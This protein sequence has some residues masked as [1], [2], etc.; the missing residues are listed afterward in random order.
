MYVTRWFVRTGFVTIRPGVV[1]WKT[2]SI[3][4]R[5]IFLLFSVLCIFKHDRVQMLGNCRPR[6]FVP[7]HAIASSNGLT[8]DN[9]K[10]T[11]RTTCPLLTLSSKCKATVFS[12]TFYNIVSAHN[13]R[14][15]RFQDKIAQTTVFEE[16]RRFGILQCKRLHIFS[17]LSDLYIFWVKNAK[18]W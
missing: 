4:L 17:F 15:R 8:D 7:G 1:F 13:K 5:S 2:N 12:Q 18:T 14:D 6:N 9:G 10:Y 16:Q 11:V 3:L